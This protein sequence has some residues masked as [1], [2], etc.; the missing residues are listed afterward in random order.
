MAI[1]QQLYHI[2]LQCRV[3]A[4]WIISQLPPP[5]AAH[6]L[7]F[8]SSSCS[9]LPPPCFSPSWASL[10]CLARYGVN[11]TPKNISSCGKNIY[12]KKLNFLLSI[13]QKK[14]SLHQVKHR[15]VTYFFKYLKQSRFL[16]ETNLGYDSGT[17][18][19]LMTKNQWVKNL[20]PGDFEPWFKYTSAFSAFTYSNNLAGK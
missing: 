17:R 19:F 11:L 13:W 1:L 18:W 5:T 16:F 9:S 8:V 3:I 12:Y 2:G 6:G 15:R 10:S 7:G 14:N 4:F 20:L